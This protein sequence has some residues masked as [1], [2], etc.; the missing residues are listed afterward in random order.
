[1]R[2]IYIAAV[3]ASFFVF[4]PCP[5]VYCADETI[6]ITTYYPAPSG[7]YNELRASKMTVSSTRAMPTA[8]GELYWGNSMAILTSDQGGAIELGGLNGGNP[9]TPF[10][11]FHRDNTPFPA[12]DYSAR[13]WLPS[14]G[15]LQVVGNLAVTGRLNASSCKDYTYPAVTYC[16]D[17]M[18]VV[19]CGT[20]SCAAR[21][22]LNALD[23]C[24]VSGYMICVK[25]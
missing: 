8:D 16:P 20:G 22:R 23:A 18:Y 17:N 12:G 19:A 3:I 21:G 15:Q 7:S 10:I 5:R 4:F 11:D 1:M 24:P 14:A 9:G 6:T 13:I 25:N 2:F